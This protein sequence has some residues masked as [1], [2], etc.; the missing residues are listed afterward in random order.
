MSTVHQE[1]DGHSYVFAFA[2]ALTTRQE[3][4]VKITDE[5]GRTYGPV[6]V[7]ADEY[8]AEVKGDEPGTSVDRLPRDVALRLLERAGAV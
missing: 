3:G 2:G 7:S 4:S 6:E 8:P 1:I 5:E